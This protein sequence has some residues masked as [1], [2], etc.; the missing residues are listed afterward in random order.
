MENSR[1]KISNETIIITFKE[2]LVL[3]MNKRAQNYFGRSNPPFP[4]SEICEDLN[5]LI[6]TLEDT[7]MSSEYKLDESPLKMFLDLKL[8]KNGIIVKKTMRSE[9]IFKKDDKKT[10]LFIN[11]PFENMEFSKKSLAEYHNA[12]TDIALTLRQLTAVL[13][14]ETVLNPGGKIQK[15]AKNVLK[16]LE[17]STRA[18][19]SVNRDL[20]VFLE[21]FSD[22]IDFSVTNIT[23]E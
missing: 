12:I 22:G 4:V 10:Q 9:I 7:Q 3:T 11:F 8:L 16:N 19:T 20:T 23:N 17:Y 18:L 21:K 13:V 5:S 6:S 2:G 1:F 15:R 14:A